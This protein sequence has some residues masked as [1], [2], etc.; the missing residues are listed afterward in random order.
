MPW[1]VG[2]SKLLAITGFAYSRISSSCPNSPSLSWLCALCLP[3]YPKAPLR[4]LKIYMHP[5]YHSHIN[6]RTLI[7]R[8]GS[9]S[10]HFAWRL[11]SAI[12]SQVSLDPLFC[13][14]TARV[15]MTKYANT[16]LQPSCGA[17]FPLQTGEY[18]P[19]LGVLPTWLLL[20]LFFGLHTGGMAR[21]G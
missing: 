19:R 5:L 14:R 7:L 4:S 6:P 13:H 18:E 2:P 17:T 11:S 15:G 3:R 12:S 20:M 21:R 9:H 1:Y 16:T 10:S 8:N